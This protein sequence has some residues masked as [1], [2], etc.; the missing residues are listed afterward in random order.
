MSSIALSTL[1]KAA[2]TRLQKV[3]PIS[4]ELHRP[5]KVVLLLS[6]VMHFAEFVISVFFFNYAAAPYFVPPIPTLIDGSDSFLYAHSIIRQYGFL[7]FSWR[8]LPHF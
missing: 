5:I 6:A 7:W 8:L 2:V 1:P 3:F 4:F